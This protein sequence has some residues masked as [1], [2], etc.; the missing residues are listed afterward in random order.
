MVKIIMIA[1]EMRTMRAK[2]F[3]TIVYNNIHLPKEKKKRL[4]VSL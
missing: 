3:L 4:R 2:L 1:F